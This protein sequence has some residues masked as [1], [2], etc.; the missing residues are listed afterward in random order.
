MKRIKVTIGVGCGFRKDKKGILPTA[1]KHMLAAA[2]LFLLANFG[3][4][5]LSE[6]RGGWRDET[7]HDWIEPGY[8]FSFTTE[9]KIL[10]VAPAHWAAALIRDIFD[11]QCVVLETSEVNFELI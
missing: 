4:Y 1:R 5:T 10:A 9:E 6:V 2:T 11:Q 8:F 3:A 7:G